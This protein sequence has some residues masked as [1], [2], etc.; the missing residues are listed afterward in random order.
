MKTISIITL[1]LISLLSTGQS[2]SDTQNFKVDTKTLKAFHLYNRSGNVKVKG[3]V[4]SVATIE[5]K[6]KIKSSSAKKLEEA[7][8]EL[9]LDSMY[10][11]N[12]IYF[13]VRTEEHTF[14]IDE[15]GYGSYS[16]CCWNSWDNRV[17]VD[18]DFDIILMIPKELDLRVATHHKD[19][20]IED[21]DGNLYAR[22]HHDNLIAR[23]L[24]GT[25]SLNNHHGDIK[26]SFSKSPTED[27][28][29]RTHHGDIVIEYPGD[30]SAIALFKSHHGEF[31]TEFDWSP[32]PV[33]MVK[34][35]SGNGTRYEVGGSTAVRINDGGSSHDFSTWHGDIYVNKLK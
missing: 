13:Y 19:L 11:D 31:Y 27:C 28:S 34:S 1:C 25:V 32:E 35:T 16:S 29:Y 22:N 17:A 12:A 30:L 14:E 24:G 10:V 33:I 8:R 20:E 2:H 4:G 9:R 26:A 21:F 3:V 6:R 5:V 23:R 15:N 18:Y 7:K